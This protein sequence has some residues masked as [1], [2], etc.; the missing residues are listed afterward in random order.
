MSLIIGNIIVIGLFCAGYLPETWPQTCAV[1]CLIFDPTC[2]L[3]T[4]STLVEYHGGNDPRAVMFTSQDQKWPVIPNVWITCSLGMH[5]FGEL[6]QQPLLYETL[7]KINLR[8]VSK[9]HLNNILAEGVQRLPTRTPMGL[10][11][12]QI[13]KGWWIKTLWSYFVAALKLIAANL[14]LRKSCISQTALS[15]FRRLGNEVNTEICRPISANS[16]YLLS[17]CFYSWL[18][19]QW[20]DRISL[21]DS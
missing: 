20:F 19:W 17:P 7:K 8:Q 1:T 9:F 21:V 4:C 16:I 12:S 14:R 15:Q 18:T 11:A 5:V 3:F 10:T 6:R 2:C 13:R